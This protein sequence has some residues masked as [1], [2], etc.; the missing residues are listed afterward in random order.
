M[1]NRELSR[2]CE[3]NANAAS[4]TSRLVI[5]VGPFQALLDPTTDLIWLNYAV[6]I[7]PIDPLSVATDLL[8]LEQVFAKHK[9]TIRFEF[10]TLP[11][12]EL[13]GMLEQAGLVLQA[14]HP[15]MVCTPQSF[16]PYQAPGVTVMLLHGE[17][18]EGL[19]SAYMQILRESFEGITEP[20]PAS[21]IEQTR[22]RLRAGILH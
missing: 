4:A 12:P 22:E 6:P 13:A 19:L 5:E 3:L 18:P 9:R 2:Q 16:Q 1:T 14:S 8:E 7:R 20:P 17:A 11:W 21:E 10:N 15:V